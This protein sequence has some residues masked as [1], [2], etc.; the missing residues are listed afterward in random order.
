MARE[1]FGMVGFDL[2]PLLQGRTR[3][4]KL[5]SAYNSLIMVLE[6]WDGKQTYRKS[7]AGT[8]EHAVQL[9]FTVLLYSTFPENYAFLSLS[10]SQ[11]K[12]TQSADTVPVHGHSTPVF[13]RI[14][15]V[16]HL[17][18]TETKNILA[19]LCYYTYW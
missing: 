5:K 14:R 10:L 16:L 15:M 4:A 19:I 7:L 3:I 13:P 18:D 6:V 1:S 2:G 11:I 9:P 17:R 8:L 12:T